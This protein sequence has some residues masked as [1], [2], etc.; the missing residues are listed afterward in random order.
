MAGA[1]RDSPCHMLMER[2]SVTETLPGCR[3]SRA[4]GTRSLER[5]ALRCVVPKALIVMKKEVYK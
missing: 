2:A 5:K 1:S 4:P 3:Q